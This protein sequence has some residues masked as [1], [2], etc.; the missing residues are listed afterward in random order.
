MILL[1]YE[2]HQVLL[3]LIETTLKS[4]FY[5]DKGNNWEFFSPI[6]VNFTDMNYL[7]LEIIKPL[8]DHRDQTEGF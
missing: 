7:N 8:D 3:Y 5:L 4:I 2:I 6:R 1:T